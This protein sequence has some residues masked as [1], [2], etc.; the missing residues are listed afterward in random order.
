MRTVG[1]LMPGDRLQLR[2]SARGAKSITLIVPEYPR[3]YV[4]LHFADRAARA[5][6][7]AHIVLLTVDMPRRRVVAQYQVTV[8]MK[9]QVSQVQWMSVLPP[10]ALTQATARAREVNEAVARYILT[11]EPPNKPMDACTNPHG[12]LPQVLRR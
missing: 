12:N 10:H 6:A 4:L 7:P 9:P 5:V 2:P 1:Y 11:C 8:A 3:P